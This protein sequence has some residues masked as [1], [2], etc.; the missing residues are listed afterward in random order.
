CWPGDTPARLRE[1]TLNCHDTA[2]IF[3]R[4]LIPDPAMAK[5]GWLAEL[6]TK[7]LGD[8]LFQSGGER[9]GSFELCRLGPGDELFQ[10]AARQRS[11]LSVNLM[12][13]EAVTTWARRSWVRLHGERLLICECFLPGLI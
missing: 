9:E 11:D 5:D 12:R 6:G 2:M 7:P 10:A 8:V 4:T 13:D 3:A 1:V